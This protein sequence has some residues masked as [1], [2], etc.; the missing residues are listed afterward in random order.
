MNV[1]N[2]NYISVKDFRRLGYLQELNRLFLHPLGMALEID[3]AADGTET[4]GGI[5]DYRD[6]PEGIIFDPSE[7]DEEFVDRA[8]RIS[9]ERHK[10][11]ESRLELLGFAIQ[12]IGTE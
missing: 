8:I 10:L 12:P 11:V 6:D 9:D 2:I 7:I 4:L 5:W 3:V 1:S